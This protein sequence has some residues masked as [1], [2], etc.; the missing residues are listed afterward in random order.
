[1][2]SSSRRKFIGSGLADQ[3]FSSLITLSVS[4]TVLALSESSDAQHFSVLVLVFGI[5]VALAR[6]VTTEP[7]VVFAPVER[8]NSRDHLDGSHLVQSTVIGLIGVCAACVLFGISG[9][10][11]LMVAVACTLAVGAD[12]VRTG[13]QAAGRPGGA[14]T[15][16]GFTFLVVAVAAVVAI[17]IGDPTAVII[18]WGAS[19][20]VGLA[21][22]FF[23]SGG[24]ASWGPL[25][26]E[27]YSFLAEATVTT[28]ASQGAILIGAALLTPDLA[29]V[30]R[31]GATVF[32]PYLAVY[33]ATALLA[34]PYFRRHRPEVGPMFQAAS[35]SI[36]LLAIL[37]GSAIPSVLILHAW[38]EPI[39][40]DSWLAFR[41]FAPSYLLSLVAGTLTA[42]VF[43]AVRATGNTRSS[44][45]LRVW[46]GVGQ[47][48]VPFLVLW[49][50]GISTYYVLA[51]IVTVLVAALGWWILRKDSR[52]PLS[53]L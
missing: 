45:H 17:L 50:T 16:T 10:F 34:I 39:L 48:V 29:V 5:L 28:G 24:Y 46:S 31:V 44:L 37:L 52:Q 11:G 42:G 19:S 35:V 26:P 32:G 23:M 2:T 51:S 38:G 8:G 36:V 40:G 22:G 49:T 4:L 13:L 47:V 3:G 15:L 20:A 30:A 12:S 9:R 7:A 41:D 18:G 25:K 1:V 27:T 21:V 33:Q 43:L 53:G 14:A 6:S